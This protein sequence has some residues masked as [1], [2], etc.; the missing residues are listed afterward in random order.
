MR[1]VIPALIIAFAMAACDSDSGSSKVELDAQQQAQVTENSTNTVQAAAS[2]A[3]LKADPGSGDAFTRLSSI[4]SYA[5]V[6]WSTKASAD[7]GYSSYG[8]DSATETFGSALAADCYTESGTTITYNCDDAGT[9]I[10]GTIALEGDVVVIDLTFTSAQVNF[11]YKGSIT[12]TE[13]SV[14]GTLDMTYDMDQGAQPVEFTLAIAY[15]AVVLT[16]GCPTA[17]SLN[18][19][20]DVNYPNLDAVSAAAMSSAIQDVTID[21][22]PTCGE[23]TM[24]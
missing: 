23:A 13:T 22:G 3:K 20:V 19:D 14:D 18:I 6:L 11:T 9:S 12:V 21:F 2:L 1:T 15:N 7:S 8:L 24:S 10:I 4:F 17:G 16:D 5:S